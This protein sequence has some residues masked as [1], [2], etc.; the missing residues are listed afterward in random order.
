MCV[1]VGY[2]LANMGENT[3]LIVMSDHGFG[4]WRRE[5]NVNA[6]LKE[7]GYLTVKNENVT[8]DPGMF[9]NTDLTQT[10]AYNVGLNALYINVAGRE[11]S[12]IVPPA[13]R[14]A[15]IDDIAE[16]LLATVDPATGQAAITRV[17]KRDQIFQSRGE[18]ENGPDIIIG[19][20]EGTRGSG[21]SAIGAVGN[22]IF[23]DNTEDWSGDHEWDHETV[24]GVLFA[25]RPLKRS[26]PRLQDVGAAILAEYDIDEPVQPAD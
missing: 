1:I 11:A 3:T 12:G 23:K 22:E 18:I 2:T 26:A 5:F 19:Y 9:V 8:N 24:P 21:D 13:E 6:W 14:D 10:R 16:K 20:A 4:S 17:Y 15:L 7:Y 25:S